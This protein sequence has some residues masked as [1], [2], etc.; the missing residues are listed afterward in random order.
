[1]VKLKEKVPKD[2]SISNDNPPPT[3]TKGEP[4]K[5]NPSDNTK[6]QTELNQ[7]VKTNL[8]NDINQA[9]NGTEEDKVRAI[10]NAGKVHGESGF[11]EQQEQIQ[12]LE[13][14][15]AQDNPAKYR[16]GIIGQIEENL[17]K[18]KLSEAELDSEVKTE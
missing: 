10:K 5:E 7:E 11:E 4:E 13:D 8:Q 12:A 9:Q 15:L 16:E 3:G 14:Q 1:L 6:N 17:S 2:S 18:N